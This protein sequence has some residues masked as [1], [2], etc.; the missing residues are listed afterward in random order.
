MATRPVP[1]ID[2][3]TSDRSYLRDA[4]AHADAVISEL[5]KYRL[6]IAVCLETQDYLPVIEQ[7]DMN[8]LKQVVADLLNNVDLTLVLEWLQ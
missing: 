1:S 5:S 6:A 4:L 3:Q 7:T 2:E 8:Q